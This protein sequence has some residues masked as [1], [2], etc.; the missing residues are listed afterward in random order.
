M[1]KKILILD[2]KEVII[3]ILLFYF[4]D[5]YDVVYFEN[6]LLGIKWIEDGNIPDLIISDIYMPLMTGSEFLYFMKNNEF[7]KDI[8]IVILSVEDSSTERIK[9]LKAGAT[10]FILKPFN[11]EELKV[12]LNKILS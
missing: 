10:D 12:R 7:Y 2:D 3:K 8:P 9:L 5:E 6:P 11:P 4:S 1:A